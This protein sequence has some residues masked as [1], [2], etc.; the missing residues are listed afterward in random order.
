MDVR[1]FQRFVGGLLSR[2]K[3]PAI[4][5]A[6][7]VATLD[8][9]AGDYATLSPT[10]NVTSWT[11]NNAP[12]SGLAQ[13]IMIL[14]TQDSTARTVA[15]PASFKFASGAPNTVSTGSG[16]KDLIGLTTFDGGTTWYVSISKTFA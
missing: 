11:I 4:S 3:V 9:L 10:A 8:C 5:I 7:G 1:G 2:S 6:S 14:F 15:W 13:T 16:A 12:P